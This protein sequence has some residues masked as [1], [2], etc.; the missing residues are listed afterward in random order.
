M[1]EHEPTAS[2][3]VA[4]CGDYEGDTADQRLRSVARKIEDHGEVHAVFKDVDGE[5]EL[6]LGTTCIDY[7]T[8]T[9]EVWDGDTYQSFPLDALVR[10]RKPMGVLHG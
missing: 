6:R 7:D 1:T 10:V 4:V 3:G 8:D 2:G 9:F 5:V